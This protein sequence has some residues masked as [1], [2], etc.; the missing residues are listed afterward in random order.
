MWTSNQFLKREYMSWQSILFNVIIWTGFYFI[1][2]YDILEY[3]TEWTFYYGVLLVLTIKVIHKLLTKGK[4]KRVVFTIN[5]VDKW[6]QTGT[7]IH[8][9]IPAYLI[10]FIGK[11]S[12]EDKWLIFQHWPYLIL[13]I[14]LYFVYKFYTQGNVV[15]RQLEIHDDNMYFIEAKST[16]YAPIKEFQKIKISYN[17]ISV[18]AKDGR[19]DRLGGYKMTDGDI[20]NLIA[21]LNKNAP[22]IELETR[23]ETIN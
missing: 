10:G 8:I 21:F 23:Y 1:L 19:R 4:D 11:Q 14:V 9:L 18:I 15:E 13:V 6:Y 5:A 16:Y 2:S 7:L 12:E 17:K 22:H 20:L 3:I